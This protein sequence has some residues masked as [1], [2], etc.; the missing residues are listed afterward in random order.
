MKTINCEDC[1]ERGEYNV[2]R[3]ITELSKTIEEGVIDDDG[4]WK[5]IGRRNEILHQCPTCKSIKAD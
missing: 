1:R 2:M 4:K 5:I 3:V